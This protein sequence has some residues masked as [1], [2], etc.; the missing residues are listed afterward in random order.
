MYEKA[1]F[2]KSFLDKTAHTQ[3]CVFVCSFSRLTRLCVAVQ[4][5]PPTRHLHSF[6]S[7]SHFSS[8]SSLASATLH[9]G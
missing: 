3:T 1:D 4:G 7:E 9:Q 2:Y 6:L 5:P 8:K